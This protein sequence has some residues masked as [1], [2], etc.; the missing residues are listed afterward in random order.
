MLLQIPRTLDTASVCYVS[1]LIM[2]RGNIATAGVEFPP[3][4]RCPSG[5]LPIP[6]APG[7]GVWNRAPGGLRERTDSVPA[8][9][10]MVES[11]AFLSPRR[12]HNNALCQ[13]GGMWPALYRCLNRNQC[14]LGRQIDHWAPF[15]YAHACQGNG[16]QARGIDGWEA[17]AAMADIFEGL[18]M[19]DICFRHKPDLGFS[20]WDECAARCRSN[21]QERREKAQIFKRKLREICD[22]MEGC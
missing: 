5:G 11:V 9:C 12:R 2:G 19:T 15:S 13:D 22:V 16:G 17:R 3:A 10:F 1:I 4:P 18:K 7:A 8:G 14:A 6:P 20:S 21:S